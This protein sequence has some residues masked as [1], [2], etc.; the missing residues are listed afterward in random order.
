MKRTLLFLVSALVLMTAPAFAGTPAAE[1]ETGE[2]LI[3]VLQMSALAVA[4]AGAVSLATRGRLGLGLLLAT[5]IT[6]TDLRTAYGT[7]YR[8]GSKSLSD[9]RVKLFESAEW[10]KL[11]N[12]EYTTLTTWEK[13][14][15]ATGAF[16]QRFQTDFTPSGSVTF[17]PTKYNLDDI[18]IDAQFTSHDIKRDF[19]GFMHRT[20]LPQNQQQF[21][22]YVIDLI[23]NQHV[24]DVEIYGAWGG[25][26][27]TITPGT[28]TTASGMMDG[29]RKVINDGITAQTIA[30]IDMGPLPTTPALMVAYV[31][32]FCK[33]IPNT[34]KN[35]PM[36]LVMN[37]DAEELFVEGMRTKYNTYYRETDNKQRV[38]VRKNIEVTGQRAMG[39]SSKIWATPMNNVYKVVNLGPSRNP[40]FNWET[41]DRRI[42]VWMDYML[43][44]VIW[45][46]GRFYTND[47]SLGTNES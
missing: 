15:V 42:K 9:L 10:D 38:Y 24:E 16:T 37:L 36:K 22:K 43:K 2:T 12:I 40:Q 41:Q 6:T 27:A 5:T 47:V 3:H 31:E 32:E 23:A 18:K 44:Y 26:N 20:G 33:Q 11:F 39:D 46:H 30:P 19:I 1:P 17:T 34:D 25:R 4:A 35:T 28:A 45:Q 29:F 8:D 7:E 13:G 14:N 21:V